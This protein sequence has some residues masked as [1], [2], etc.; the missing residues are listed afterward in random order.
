MVQERGG[1]NV[2]PMD[3]IPCPVFLT[4]CD[5]TSSRKIPPKTLDDAKLRWIEAFHKCFLFT[6]RS[7]SF[8]C[9]GDGDDDLAHGPTA[10]FEMDTK[11]SVMSILSVGLPMPKS[12]SQLIGEHQRGRPVDPT[13]EEREE[14]GWWAVR[15]RQVLREI[16]R[17]EILLLLPEQPVALLNTVAT[18]SLGRS[19]SHLLP[20]ALAATRMQSTPSIETHSRR[21][22]ILS[23]RPLLLS[24]NIGTITLNSTSPARG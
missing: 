11:T 22:S 5:R 24:A 6:L 2:S 18:A 10:D 9:H 20:P 12:P 13:E 16:Q 3:C 19:Q 4:L 7:L 14:R 8:P 15:F 23:S 17:Q 21:R 1:I